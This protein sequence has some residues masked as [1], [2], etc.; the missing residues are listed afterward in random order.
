MLGEGENGVKDIRQGY[1][2]W[3]SAGG[4]FVSSQHAALSAVSLLEAGQINAARDFVQFGETA[5]TETGERHVAAELQ[6]LRGRFADLENN[7]VLAE[8]CYR[9]AIETAE[10]QGARLFT[11]RAASDLATLLQSRGRGEEAIAVLSPIYDWFSS[12]WDY[13]DLRRA[14]T[15]MASLRA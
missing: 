9:Q 14:K 10:R 4:R 15:V 7:G 3:R 5:Q 12:G 11:L 2:L 1:D 6:R 8:T 13:P